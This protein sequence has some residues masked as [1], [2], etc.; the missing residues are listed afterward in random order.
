MAARALGC[1]V[2]PIRPA[3]RGGL[4]DRLF[5]V[6][7]ASGGRWNILVEYKAGKGKLSQTQ[8]DWWA[9]WRG[10]RPHIAR[11]IE[12]VEAIVKGVRNRGK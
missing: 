3:R 2:E 7:D 10:E 8:L 6:P 11:T 4:P 9:A 5:G 1:S 12:D